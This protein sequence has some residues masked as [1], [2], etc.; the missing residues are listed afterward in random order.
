M[1]FVNLI[2][3]IKREQGKGK[4][5][6]EVLNRYGLDGE[7]FL[8]ILGIH[9]T[10]EMVSIVNDM[11]SRKESF[12]STNPL[13]IYD[14]VSRDYIGFDGNFMVVTSEK[15]IINNDLKTDIYHF[16]KYSGYDAFS[17]D[18]K[19]SYDNKPERIIS[20]K[21]LLKDLE[22]T[23]NFLKD[24]LYTYKVKI[25]NGIKKDEFNHILRLLYDAD[26]VNSYLA[27]ANGN[28]SNMIL[29]DNFY[30]KNMHTNTLS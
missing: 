8:N 25:V 21:Y 5:I 18:M 20:E 29:K 1:E 12:L 6:L 4:T 27:F 9:P 14:R 28:Y 17:F 13:G 23:V 11:M 3:E 7:K 16:K 2:N 26:F 19:L 22:L 30:N 15:P 24:F 10:S